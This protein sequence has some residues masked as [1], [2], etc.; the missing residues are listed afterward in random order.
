MSTQ[1]FFR[2]A[3]A[4]DLSLRGSVGI[5]LAS[6]AEADEGTGGNK[7][8]ALHFGPLMPSISYKS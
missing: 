6:L 3:G 2:I 7:A 1:G 8:R 4:I 5:D